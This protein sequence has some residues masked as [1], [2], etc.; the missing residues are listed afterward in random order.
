M[1][2]QAVLT[3]AGSR[4]DSVVAVVVGRSCDG[5]HSKT[6][7]EESSDGDHVGEAKHSV[8]WCM[9]GVCLVALIVRYVLKPR[10]SLYCRGTDHSPRVKRLNHNNVRWKVQVKKDGKA[11]ASRRQVRG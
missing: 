9:T 8:R 6:Y 4:C 10:S 11:V 5:S 3:G 7:D 2:D 1:Y